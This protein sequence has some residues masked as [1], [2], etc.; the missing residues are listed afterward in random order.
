LSALYLTLFV[1]AVLATLGV[2]FFAFNVKAKSHEHSDRLALLPLF[3]DDD[4]GD[5]SSVQ[6]I[7][8]PFEKAQEARE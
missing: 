4:G 1:S 7:S 3:D 5:P 6:E 8:D 2:L